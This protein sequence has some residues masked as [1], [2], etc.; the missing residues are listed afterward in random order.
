MTGHQHEK[1]HKRLWRRF[2]SQFPALWQEYQCAV[3]RHGVRRVRLVLE[4]RK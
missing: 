3:K 4:V 1:V 2:S